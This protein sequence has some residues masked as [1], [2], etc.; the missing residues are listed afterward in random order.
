MNETNE[1]R[2]DEKNDKPKLLIATTVPQTIRAF[3]LPYADHFR[4]R[5]WRVDALAREAASAQAL[6]GHFDNIYDAPWDR[7]PLSPGNLPALSQIARLVQEGG[8]DIV[9]VHT[10]VAAFV[11]RAALRKLRA[12]E[13]SKHPKIVYT[14]HGFHFYR[15][16]SWRRNLVF[17]NLEK[18]AGK[19][20]DRLIVINRED[21]E[22]AK[23][24]RIVPAD[25][26]DQLVYMPGIGLDF[27]KYDGEDISREDILAVRTE[28]GLKDDDVLYSMLA[29][30]NPGKR[31]KDVIAALSKTKN[32]QIHVAFAGDGPLKQKIQEMARAYTVHQR[33]HFLGHLKNPNAL[34]AASRATL[35]PSERE[36]LSRSA[37]ESAC[38]GVP[39]IGTDAR[40]VR[41]VIEPHRGLLYP[42]GDQLAL[43]DAMLRMFEEPYPPVEPDSAWRIESL[44]DMHEALYQELLESE[45]EEEPQQE[46]VQDTNDEKTEEEKAD[47]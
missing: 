18:T 46:T 40:G 19:W 27:S 5:G 35:V 9:H 14:A 21:F 17:R 47:A 13:G 22:A 42:A 30:F 7:S 34:M 45:K 44:I 20:T 8:Y 36:G 29:E 11:T 25:K 12:T 38:L 24:Y 23:T 39:I 37:M 2:T 16:G 41:D 43:R 15:G 6:E 33:T 1:T 10:P 28:L 32:P 26:G 4:G 31:H 3:L